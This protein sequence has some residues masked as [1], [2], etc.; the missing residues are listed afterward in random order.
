[1]ALRTNKDKTKVMTAK[2]V[3]AQTVRLASGAN[4]EVQDFTYLRRVF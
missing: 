2:T 4:D 1:V 3:S